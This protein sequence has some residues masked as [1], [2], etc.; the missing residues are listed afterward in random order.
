MN[1]NFLEQIKNALVCEWFMLIVAFVLLLFRKQ[2]FEVFDGFYHL[3]KYLLISFT[4]MLG[5]LVEALF[6]FVGQMG[7]QSSFYLNDF[8]TNHLLPWLLFIVVVDI[9]FYLLERIINILKTDYSFGRKSLT[10]ARLAIYP[11]E[12]KDFLLPQQRIILLQ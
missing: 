5:F 11:K 8:Y 6:I 4:A 12:M 1:N 10:G 3:I 2:C 7:I 9:V